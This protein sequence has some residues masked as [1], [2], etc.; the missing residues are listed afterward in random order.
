MM[1][2]SLIFCTL[3]LE[4][5]LYESLC[6]ISPLFLSQR[7]ELFSW[8]HIL[9]KTLRRTKMLL[10]PDW[11]KILKIW[12]KLFELIQ[13]EVQCSKSYFKMFLSQE[14]AASEKNIEKESQKPRP[15]L[16]KY[17]NEIL[18]DHICSV[19]NVMQVIAFCKHILI[20]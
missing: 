17:V 19:C 8:T 9:K 18:N 3:N 12:D 6:H 5:F 4:S 1:N 7:N 15:K 14:N 16:Q 10:F 13:I 2:F 11:N 20:L